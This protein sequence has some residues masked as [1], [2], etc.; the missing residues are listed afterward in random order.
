M[1]G[2]PGLPPLNSRAARELRDR[3]A[4]PA[5]E[6]LPPEPV[7]TVPP[8]DAAAEPFRDVPLPPEPPPEDDDHP[9]GESPPGDGVQLDAAQLHERLVVR[10]VA[11]Q[12]VRLEARAV[13]AGEQAAATLSTL[14]EPVSLEVA[15]AAPEPAVRWRVEGLLP[16]EGNAT[17]TATRKTG[18]TTTVANLLRAL[19]DG[20]PFLDAFPVVPLAGRVALLNYEVAHDQLTRWLRALDLEHPE[21]VSLFPLRGHRVPLLTDDGAA[22]LVR[23]LRK[24]EAEVMVVDPFG[25]AFVAA[26]GETENDNT[27]VL[28][29]LA[30]LDEIKTAAGVSE[31]VMLV[32]G[33][34]DAMEGRERS[35]GASALEDW[36]DAL[37]RLTADD[38]GARFLSAGGRDVDVPEQRLEYD[39]TTRRLTLSGGSR[40]QEAMRPVQEDIVELL[41]ASPRMSGRKIEAALEARELTRDVVRG[42]LAQL[43]KDGRVVVEDGPNRAHLHS[44]R[45]VE[46]TLDMP[47]RG[48]APPVRQRTEGECAGALISARTP[49]P[50]PP[51]GSA[52]EEDSAHPPTERP[53]NPSPGNGGERLGN[54]ETVQSTTDESAGGCTVCG[55]P[56]T[57]PTARRTGRCSRLDADHREA[58]DAAS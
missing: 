38:N 23:R 29:F 7:D 26:G 8:D 17:L 4:V 39:P 54:G 20:L 15:L 12:R 6:S 1:S 34:R 27:G 25:R 33:N 32:H 56:L 48:S 10:E 52:R 30:R 50:P 3:P 46:N 14:P 40:R 18:K 21:R 51:E 28:R 55:E 57:S 58:R 35:R 5:V 42:A 49:P 47:V 44:I 24:V 45:S 43:V 22:W 36:P 53:T 9:A 19:A 37:W 13:L 11:Q 16:A 2:L 41:E 31:L